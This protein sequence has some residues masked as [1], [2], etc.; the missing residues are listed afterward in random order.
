VKRTVL[1]LT[2]SALL[3]APAHAVG[4]PREPDRVPIGFDLF[5]RVVF[6]IP[7]TI[8]GAAV[9]IPA[10]LATAIT[11]PSEMDKTWDMLVMA[12][13]RY[14][15]VDPLGYHPEP[16]K[17]RMVTTTPTVAETGRD[18]TGE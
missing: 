2:L 16:P 12:P 14:T 18:I 11:R 15:W 1:I 8:A 9:M 10:G 3:A 6:G 13:V 7:L 5:T 4:D 17:R